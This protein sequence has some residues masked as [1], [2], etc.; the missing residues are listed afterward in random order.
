MQ[1]FKF[2]SSQ[3]N[4]VRDIE[5]CNPLKRWQKNNLT[6]KTK[7]SLK[8]CMNSLIIMIDQLRLV[9]FTNRKT[10]RMDVN[11]RISRPFVNKYQ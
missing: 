11:K 2:S 8:F 5:D 9:Q 6:I 7:L 1:S 4:K 10:G 3:I